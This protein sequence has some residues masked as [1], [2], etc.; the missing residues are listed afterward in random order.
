M[1]LLALVQWNMAL[2]MAG[3]LE[4]DDLEIPFQTE[5]FSVI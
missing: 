5:L 2:L 4:L 1:G 3:G